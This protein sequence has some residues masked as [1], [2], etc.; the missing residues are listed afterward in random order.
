MG[1]YRLG[2]R[3]AIGGM[4][5]VYLASTV[6]VA[7][8]SKPVAVKRV[9]PH[10]AEDRAFVEH[11]LQEARLTEALQHRNL[12]QVLDLGTQ[13]GEPYMILELVDGENLRT[14]LKACARAGQQLTLRE[15][16]CISMQVAEGLAH[17][18]E[19]TSPQGR[20][21]G[22][23]HRDI[24]PANV[25]LSMSGEVKL[26]DF[27][28]A[29]AA[30]M[31]SDTQVGVVKG[32]PGY[33]SPEQ[34]RGRPASQASDVFL[35]GLLLHE[36][37]TG[38]ALFHG[39]P[40]FQAIA[41]I[42]TFHPSQLERPAAVPMS[43]WTVLCKALRPNPTERM[44][45]ARE[46]AHA[47]ED[48]L[49]SERLRVGSRDLAALLAR[50]FPERVS[51]LRDPGL[52]DGRVV[53]LDPWLGIEGEGAREDAEPVAAAAPEAWDVSCF[54]GDLEASAIVDASEIVQ[55]GA[56]AVRARLAEEDAFLFG[57]APPPEAPVQQLEATAFLE[58]D[59][60]ELIDEPVACAGAAAQGLEER[61]RAH[62]PYE[63]APEEVDAMLALEPVE[64]AT[65]S[66]A[67]GP[68]G[69]VWQHLLG[70]TLQ[71]VS[72]QLGVQGSLMASLAVR[73]GV[74]LGLAAPEIG[75]V[76]LAALTLAVGTGLDATHGTPTL[77]QLKALL[78]QHWSVACHALEGCGLFGADIAQQGPGLA[79]A[80]A[81][82]VSR[83]GGTPHEGSDP[84]A[85]LEAIRRE[86]RLPAWA[87]PA[88]EE[89][90][91]V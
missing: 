15:A 9:L 48:F 33:L 84:Q 60:F 29:R 3:I 14:L 5:E 53:T 51:V 37:I 19:S 49:F 27:G 38:K 11:F 43:L 18:H 17:A 77:Q 88:L 26:A 25:L 81:L 83:S 1:T 79:L 91:R 56:D 54:F 8:F 4:A 74:H 2:R 64:E 22:L 65:A 7:G 41:R 59:E 39:L 76:R 45:S 89:A 68:E 13:A 40:F 78:G 42:R 30:E 12:V 62:G 46:F 28:I 20:P 36:L 75:E 86:G 32:K 61:S 85:T 23:V 66:Q 63:F 16:V 21:L 57:S 50:V 82:E 35:L 69:E 10:M 90:L 34:V 80:A 52:T 87:L 67:R 71:A 73:I 72:P 47:L 70:A 55:E 24:N 58:A 6:G 44:G 31:Q